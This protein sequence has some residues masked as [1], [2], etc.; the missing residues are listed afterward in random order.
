MEDVDTVL[1]L[2]D[3]FLQSPYLTGSYSQPANNLLLFFIGFVL[4]KHGIPPGGIPCQGWVIHRNLRSG[5]PPIPLIT[6]SIFSG[7]GESGPNFKI[8]SR[9]WPPDGAPSQLIGLYSLPFSSFRTAI[10]V[11]SSSRSTECVLR[12]TAKA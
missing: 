9:W 1:I 4:H 2:L 7:V 10:F 8:P 5:M 3:H 6:S 12:T 11:R